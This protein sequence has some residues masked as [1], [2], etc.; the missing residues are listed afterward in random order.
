L[1]AAGATTRTGG[2][3]LENE[4]A[5]EKRLH[6]GLKLALDLGPI[7]AFFVGYLLLRDRSVSIAGTEYSGFIV[8]TALFI[9]LLAF[10]TWLL[11]RLTGKVSRMQI[12]T[13]VLVVVFGG[14]TIWLNDER[15]FK[16]KPTMIYALFA[17]I[18]AF[19]LLRGQSY[20]Q[21]VMDEVLPMAQEGWMILTR[22]VT[23]FFAGLA[24]LNEVVW[25]TMSTDAWVNFKTFGLTIA[26]FA[27]FMA[28]SKL[29]QTY[30]TAEPE[31]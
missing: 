31:D 21:M 26:V 10:T 29:F 23:A 20:M 12:M 15:F 14:L 6:G 3:L 7:L 18:L 13:L 28:Q 16:M 17:G 25:R 4:L 27:F 2:R 11:K 8:V 22:R 30:S 1:I 24:V 5:E 9:P 19:G